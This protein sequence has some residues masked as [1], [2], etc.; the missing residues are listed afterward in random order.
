MTFQ[1][2]ID[3]L[4]LEPKHAVW[5]SN[6]DVAA[7]NDLAVLNRDVLAERLDFLRMS[8]DPAAAMERACSQIAKNEH[9]QHLLACVHHHLFIEQNLVPPEGRW[10]ALPEH[11]GE[12]GALI[13]ALA[14]LEAMPSALAV[15]TQRGIKEHVARATLADLELWM[16]DFFER[17]GRWGM[18]ESGWMSL[19]FRAAVF[20]LGRLQFE[21]SV[22]D[23]AC[24]LNNATGPMVTGDDVLSLHIPAIGPM[25]PQQCDDSFAEATLFFR[26]HF[27]ERRFVAFT[28]A[29]WL[30]DRQLAE[31]LP[32]ESNIVKFLKRFEPL[33]LK[34][35][36]NRQMLERVF[37]QS[38][39]DPAAAP[40]DTT[41][42]RVIAD[43]MS[44]GDEWKMGAGYISIPQADDEHDS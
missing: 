16:R 23:A 24:Y 37:G 19:H 35:A 7:T 31:H 25:T 36:D 27:S 11:H 3:G 38:K 21:P 29:S 26:R 17:S 18:V 30:L 6:F 5:R 42:R 12:G 15:Y 44:R 33:T 32:A 8:T 14:C 41:L 1:E 22:F 10:P 34:L 13:Y 40:R 9:L 4:D 28:C 2:M 39:I 20:A 43:S